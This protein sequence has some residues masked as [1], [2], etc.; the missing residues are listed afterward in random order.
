LLGPVSARHDQ[1]K[2]ERVPGRRDAE[3][4]VAYTL[5]VR[6]DEHGELRDV[7]LDGESLWPIWFK[8]EWKGNGHLG[9]KI[10]GQRLSTREGDEIRFVTEA[11]V[12]R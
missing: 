7:L 8:V 11:P 6:L 5:E 12:T 4:T 3:V 1:L 9:A 10:A 2:A